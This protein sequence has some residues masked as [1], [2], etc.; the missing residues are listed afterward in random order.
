MQ[1]KDLIGRAAVLIHFWTLFLQSR[2]H[3]RLSCAFTHHPMIVSCL[4]DSA[5]S[6]TSE[7]SKLVAHLREDGVFRKRRVNAGQSIELY[8]P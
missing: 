2:H 7:V 1:K 3:L 6:R 4:G 8:F 5:R